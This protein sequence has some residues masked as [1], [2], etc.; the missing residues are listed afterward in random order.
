MTRLN[1]S[2][3]PVTIV[4]GGASGIGA[5]VAVTLAD[6]GHRLAI[7]DLDRV[8]AEDSARRLPGDGHLGVACDVRSTPSVNALVWYA[9]EAFGGVDGVVTCAGMSR[10][11]PSADVDDDALHELLDVHLLGSIRTLRAAYP[12]LADS[13]RAAAVAMSSMGAHLGIP[14][15][16]GYCVAKGGVEAMVKTLAVEWAP[17]AI[18]VNAVAPG[19]VNTPA[20]GRLIGDGQLDERP[21]TARTPL[22]RLGEPHEIAECI[23]FLLDPTTS[24]YVTG[25]VFIIDGGLTVQGPIQAVR[26]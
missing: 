21:I 6:R 26:E 1:G 4:T 25:Q 9:A 7:A 20:I 5:A 10:L 14:G 13:P 12:Y 22:H 3:P 15:R 17:D 23:G 2:A 18:R 16:L 24:S 8:L 11:A 19:W